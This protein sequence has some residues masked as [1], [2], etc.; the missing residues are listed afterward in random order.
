MYTT[1]FALLSFVCKQMNCVGIWVYK[2]LL[3]MNHEFRLH[4]YVSELMN[5]LG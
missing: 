5:E 4:H 3:I 1:Y 2:N